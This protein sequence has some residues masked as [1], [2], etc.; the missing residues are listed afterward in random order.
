M[1]D[2]IKKLLKAISSL[3]LTVILLTL[4]MILVFIGTL[5]QVKHGLWD[6]Q[7]LYFRSLF[8]FKEVG[9]GFKVPVFP[10]GYLLGWALFINLIA[11][12]VARFKLTAK[13]TGIFLTHIGLMMLLF[14]QFLTEM[15]QVEST[16]RI[17]EGWQKNYSA[18]QLKDEIAV[19]DKSG[20]E[21][22]SY[23]SFPGKFLKEGAELKHEVIPFSV[24]VKT[25]YPN[26]EPLYS[27]QEHPEAI[28][29]SRGSGARLRI[30]P[31]DITKKMDDRNIPSALV[32]VVGK[33]GE[34][35]GEWLVSNWLADDGLA[36]A[37]R[38]DSGFGE[39]YANL[40]APQEFDYDGKTWEIALRSLRY[41][42]DFSIEL[43]DFRHDRYL[44]TDKAKNFSSRV[45]LDNPGSG[46]HREVTIRMNEPLRY[47]GE[48]YYQGSF[49]R[50]DQTTILQV[51][52]NP[53]WLTPYV[54]C[55]LIGLGLCIQ[56]G[57][58]LRRFWDRRN[59]GSSPAV[60]SKPKGKS[61]QGERKKGSANPATVAK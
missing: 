34:V 29:G 24:R 5:A 61:A 18:A 1:P 26:S 43:H 36:E 27:W 54:S 53:A 7:T 9:D 58:S 6:A 12:H 4:G 60:V 23:V 55:T 3:K 28:T 45:T 2:P 22:F 15:L 19:I 39:R 33:D 48:T 50:T 8:V 37:I 52:R 42:K 32:E 51:V 38:R 31:R 16:M 30:A 59:S 11:A 49:E 20:D 56:F 47:E 46:E 25:W 40:D 21:Q 13:K 44:G 41:Y 10:G 35:V 17:E 14:G 57:M